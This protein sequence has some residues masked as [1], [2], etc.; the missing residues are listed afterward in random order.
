MAQRKSAETKKRTGSKN[1]PVKQRSCADQ[2]KLVAPAGLPEPP[3]ILGDDIQAQNTY[4]ALGE[5]LMMYD[6]LYQNIDSYTLAIA[7]LSY[8]RY[9][10]CSKIANNPETCFVEEAKSHCARDEN[11][12]MPVTV[13]EH[14]AVKTMRDAQGDFDKALKSLGLDLKGRATIF[15]QLSMVKALHGNGAKVHPASKFFVLETGT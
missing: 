7:A 15:A 8:K 4:C 2:I 13:K 11:G 1:V 3:D 12:N 5:G 10:F 9:A 6:Q 14:P